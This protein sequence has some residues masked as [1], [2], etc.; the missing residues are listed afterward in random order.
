MEL[1]NVCGTQCVYVEWCWVKITQILL[2]T[3]N[4]F[5]DEIYIRVFFRVVLGL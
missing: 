4:I 5:I 1:I 3:P 2:A